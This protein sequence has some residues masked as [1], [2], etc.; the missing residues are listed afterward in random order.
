M[1]L[2]SQRYR[3]T[4]PSIQSIHPIRHLAFSVLNLSIDLNC[5]NCPISPVSPVLRCYLHLRWH[6]FLETNKDVFEFLLLFTSIISCFVSEE[7]GVFSSIV[8]YNGHLKRQLATS[9]CNSSWL[10]A[11]FKKMEPE[12][13]K[14]AFSDTSQELGPATVS[15]RFLRGE[16]R[17]S[18]QRGPGCR[19]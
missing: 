4:H 11:K 1:L 5:L 10:E 16:S 18:C 17:C 7:P 19:W 2:V 8:S 14:N 13:L 9:T 15:C 12:N 3:I 6:Y